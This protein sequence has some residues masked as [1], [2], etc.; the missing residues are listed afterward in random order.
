MVW[1]VV[2]LVPVAFFVSVILTALLIRIGRGVGALDSAGSTGHDK[3]IRDVPN[4]GGVAIA[5]PLIGALLAGAALV[6]FAWDFLLSI[7]PELETYQSR[8]DQTMP[9]V[10]AFAI[11][12][13]LIHIIGVLDDRRGLGPWFKLIIQVVVAAC[14]SAWFDVRL[15]RIVDEPL[16]VGPVPSIII[17]VIWIVLITNAINFMDNMDGLAGGVAAI[18]SIFLM[19]AA[20]LNDQWFIAA[21][22]AVLIGSLL[23]FL[24]FNVAPAK[25]FLGDGGSLVIG[26]TLAVLVARTT[27]YNP[28]EQG[29]GLGSGWYGIFMPLAILAVPLYDMVTV[30]LL[31]LRQ[32]R[33]PLVGD[34]QH[35]S[36]R[37][38]A[39]GL[40]P[41]GAV[42]VIW[43]IA[44]VTG[45][46]G[47]SLAH[48]AP[49]QAVLV[50]V[51]VLLVLLMLGVLEHASRRV[52]RGEGHDG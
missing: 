44:A 49:W 23:G 41:R 30:S 48:L 15:L 27:F 20:L 51:Q 19:A 13:L 38:V 40:S 42:A 9:T 5:W 2:L 39:R 12:L 28:A 10:I 14:L 36:H 8:L 29:T 37:L 17:T 25:I 22:L 24:V 43:C 6:W 35:Y 50:G 26:F 11:S 47:V 52:T 7:V 45:I 1:P 3:A 21:T 46:A 31:R 34:Q 16:G 4:I 33:S 18:A 32:G